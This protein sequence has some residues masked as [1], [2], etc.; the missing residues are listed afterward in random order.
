MLEELG[1]PGQVCHLVHHLLQGRGARVMEGR[2][3]GCHHDRLELLTELVAGVHDFVANVLGSNL[4]CQRVPNEHQFVCAQDD[5]LAV[6]HKDARRLCQA[7]AAEEG[8]DGVEEGD[9]MGLALVVVEA[10]QLPILSAHAAVCGGEALRRLPL[11]DVVL[12]GLGDFLFQQ[13]ELT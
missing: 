3:L 11:G 10:Q 12:H 7:D 4:P 6:G 13:L 1:V 9:V 5:K 8:V 2:H